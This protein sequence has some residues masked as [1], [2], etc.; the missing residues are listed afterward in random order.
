M[1]KIDDLLG[2]K[3]LEELMKMDEHEREIYF[4]E[5]LALEPRPL[6]VAL[7][8]PTKKPKTKKDLKEEIQRL[9]LEEE[10]E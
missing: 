8:A 6:G 9:L 4:A 3:P 2:A 1:A 5:A 7:F 10:E